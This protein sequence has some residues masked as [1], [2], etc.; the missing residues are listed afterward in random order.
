MFL[1]LTPPTSGDFWNP[2]NWGRFISSI[3]IPGFFALVFFGFTVWIIWKGLHKWDKH[4]SRQERIATIQLSLC[5]G[6]HS[7]GG[8]A[9]VTDFRDAGHDFAD[10]LQSIGNEMGVGEEIKN[11]IKHIHDV[12][13]NKPAPLPIVQFNGD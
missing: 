12:L 4:L 11:S 8:V 10:I 6:V 5:K 2:E 7:V 13:R 9:N 3:G 1:Q